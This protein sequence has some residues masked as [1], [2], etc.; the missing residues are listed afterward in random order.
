M[1][2]A[3][4]MVFDPSEVAELDTTMTLAELGQVRVMQRLW[5][6][7][8]LALL[9]H[10]ADVTGHVEARRDVPVARVLH[11]DR[12]VPGGSDG[13]PQVSEFAA[14]EVAALWNTP[15]EAVDARIH[16]ALN[17]RH[18][19][20]SLWRR[21]MA[22][23]LDTWVAT[24]I[25]WKATG[26]DRDAATRLDTRI[27]PVAATLPTSRLL[28]LVDAQVLKL[29]PPDQA[30]E[31]RADDRARRGVW[32]RQRPDDRATTIATLTSVL[33][34]TD[35]DAI[36]QQVRRIAQLL[37]QGGDP[38]PL[39]DRR[40]TA[41]GLMAYPARALQLLQASILDE[42]PTDVSESWGPCPAAGQAGHLC[43]QITTDPER[44]LPK[45]QIVVHLSDTALNSRHGNADS[46]TD[47]SDPHTALARVDR[48]G[49]VLTDWLADLLPHHRITV[50]LVLDVGRITPVDSYEIPD[51]MREAL[52]YRQPYDTFPGS[53]RASSHGCDLDHTTHY[54][55]GGPPGQTRLE[56]LS[57]V[58]RRAHRAKTHGGWT[59]TQPLPG[60]LIWTSPHGHTY[61]VAAGQS[62]RINTPVPKARRA[63]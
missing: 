28:R 49:P 51:R 47:I 62:V 22:G 41:L 26:L 35:A 25:T 23:Q 11:G 57:P 48:I 56:N 20:P 16:E 2:E 18:R 45:A 61:L 31:L 55:P 52:R 15:V 44:L 60:I 9:A 46:H 4:A 3:S 19:F 24:K 5:H 13:T 1:N 36:D 37:A 63:A 43:G 33:D 34:A 27:D 54:Q 38:R 7:R 42:L 14:L 30:A 59:L 32:I 40:A 8:E 29:T 39:D 58:S 21:V 10:Y 12:M 6:A 50:R 53:T 17:L